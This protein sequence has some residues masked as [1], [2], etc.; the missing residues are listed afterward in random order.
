MENSQN[1]IG[2]LGSERLNALLQE[3]TSLWN[4]KDSAFRTKQNIDKLEPRIP[5]ANPSNITRP[6]GQVESYHK[7]LHLCQDKLIESLQNMD[8]AGR[9]LKKSYSEIEYMKKKK[10]SSIVTFIFVASIVLTGLFF[11]LAIGIL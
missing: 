10:T 5:T 11:L 8:S 3:R 9:D 2:N 4:D 6:I 1:S 7:E